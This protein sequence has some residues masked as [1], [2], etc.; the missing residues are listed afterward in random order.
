MKMITDEEEGAFDDQIDDNSN[1][2]LK[3]L[4]S[5]GSEGRG[6]WL[7]ASMTEAQPLTF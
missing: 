6:I 7:S 2:W 4:A 3:S 5:E 1:L